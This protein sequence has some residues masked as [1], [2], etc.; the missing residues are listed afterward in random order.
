[1]TGCLELVCVSQ[2]LYF[3]PMCS[4]S[5]LRREPDSVF[6]QTAR[7]LHYPSWA[8]QAAEVRCS[9]CPFNPQAPLKTSPES[10]HAKAGKS[11]EETVGKWVL[12]R[13]SSHLLLWLHTSQS[14]RGLEIARTFFS[15]DDRTDLAH[16]FVTVSLVRKEKTSVGKES[17]PF[18]SLQLSGRDQVLLVRAGCAHILRALSPIFAI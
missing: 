15:R 17:L 13:S 16:P 4:L 2:S 9:G 8:I 11:K 18:P 1:M 12:V 6:W 7:E 14:P 10:Q 3:V 5:Q